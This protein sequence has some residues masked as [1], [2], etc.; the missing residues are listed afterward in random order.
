[1]AVASAVAVIFNLVLQPLLG[2]AGAAVS[3]VCAEVALLILYIQGTIRHVGGID[4]TSS[5]RI[6]T[7]RGALAC[8]AARDDVR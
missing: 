6:E 3:A 4:V 5:F 2:L 1:M 7:I 8:V